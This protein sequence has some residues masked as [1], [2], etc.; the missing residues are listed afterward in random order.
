M[1]TL[2][3]TWWPYG[4]LGPWWFSQIISSGP[5]GAPL[6]GGGVGALE[7]AG[8]RRARMPPASNSTA[9]SAR[10][11][12]TEV[13]LAFRDNGAGPACAG[14]RAGPSCCGQVESLGRSQAEFVVPAIEL[15]VHQLASSYLPHL[16]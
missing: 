9:G 2:L 13:M 3:A 10:A 15:C 11:R 4:R 12:L 8:R 16:G 7:R 14:G 1:L 5:F 6:V